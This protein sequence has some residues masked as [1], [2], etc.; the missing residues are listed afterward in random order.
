MF[1]GEIGIN[2]L[3][4]TENYF[5]NSAAAF[6]HYV[7]DEEKLISQIKPQNGQV[8]RVEKTLTRELEE[9]HNSFFANESMSYGY[10]GIQS[11]TSSYDNLAADLIRNL[12]YCR[13]EFPT[14]YHEPILAADSLLG[15]KYLLSEKPYDGYTLRTDLQ[16]YNQKAVYE[17]KNALPIAFLTSQ[18]IIGV[19]EMEENPF[20]YL[21]AIY[22]GIM[23]QPVELYRKLDGVLR[24]EQ[25]DN[26]EYV[27]GRTAENLL[28]YARIVYLKG[29]VGI[30]AEEP[31]PYESNGWLN[32]NL[33]VLGCGNTEHQ[34]TASA[35]GVEADF[36]T[37]DMELLQTLCRQIMD[38]AVSNFQMYGGNIRFE[39]TGDYA[40]L[41]IPYDVNWQV[42]V[43]DKNVS[44]QKGAGAF[45]VIPLE[46]GKMNTVTMKYK[47]RG[48]GMGIALS[49]V[50]LILLAVFVLCQ[51]RHRLKN[52]RQ[53]G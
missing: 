17:N 34:L 24:S 52:K 30:D 4:I 16:E 7:N 19:E 5:G 31:R 9:N 40:M 49:T 12:G 38:R 48:L 37:L 29:T 28:V 33:I 8:Y 13:G 51:Y 1:L 15:V 2:A 39:A 45:M 14:F 22:S 6:I 21:N 46:S 42:F 23:G 35:A 50:S 53:C 25:N 27:V 10:G 18:N 3:W 26:T 36:Y 20:A 41:T 32:H 47:V 44:A 11:Y 43:N